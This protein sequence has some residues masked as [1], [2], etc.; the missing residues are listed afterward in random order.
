MKILLIYDEAAPAIRDCE[1]Q[2][3]A[4]NLLSRRFKIQTALDETEFYE[5]RFSTMNMYRC[6]L[7]TALNMKFPHDALMIQHYKS[8]AL[9]AVP[10]HYYVNFDSI[11]FPENK[12]EEPDKYIM[13]MALLAKVRIKDKEEKESRERKAHKKAQQAM[14]DSLGKNLGK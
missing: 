4:E 14:L 2:G 7:R 8:K 11:G 3:I 12:W 10:D 9:V 6:I 13:M 5:F 1:I